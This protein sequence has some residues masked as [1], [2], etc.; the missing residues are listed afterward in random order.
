M[1]GLRNNLSRTTVFL[2]KGISIADTLTLVLWLTV[3]TIPEFILAT[4]DWTIKL[5]NTITL[6]N[7]YLFPVMVIVRHV[8]VWLTVV[9]YLQRYVAGK[10]PFRVKR[11]TMKLVIVE[12][13]VIVIVSI[14]HCIPRYFEMEVVEW[15]LPCNLEVLV[16][17]YTELWENA[18]YQLCYKVIL[19]FCIDALPVFLAS[20]LAVLL[21]K[22][23]VEQRR[24][25]STI[26]GSHI[27]PIT[28][29]ESDL[30]TTLIIIT[31]VFVLCEIPSIFHPFADCSFLWKNNWSTAAVHTTTLS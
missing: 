15:P 17:T 29:K 14:G 21:I 20:T 30:T 6:M 7:Y 28:G 13:V 16:L 27:Q 10:H 11:C 26:T 22:A 12:T 24:K 4:V 25:R 5:Y 18:I 1:F 9:V 2:L 23:L 31:I 8:S 3:R 19:G